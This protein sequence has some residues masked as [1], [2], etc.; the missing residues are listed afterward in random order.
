MSWQ[1]RVVPRAYCC[2]Q[3]EGCRTWQIRHGS[4]GRIPR[5]SRIGLAPLVQGLQG[6]NRRCRVCSIRSKLLPG[7]PLVKAW[8]GREGTRW[9]GA[10]AAPIHR[11]W[12]QPIRQAVYRVPFLGAALPV[13]Y[14]LLALRRLKH[15]RRRRRP[16]LEHRGSC[17]LLWV[18]LNQS[19]HN[20]RGT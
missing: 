1:G 5:T 20:C 16:R 18:A 7:C 2:L 11:R 19:S 17:R 12:S 8:G 6:G 3:L 4:T 13:L 9:D 10:G 15:A 14:G